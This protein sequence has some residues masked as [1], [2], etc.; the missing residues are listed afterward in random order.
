MNSEIVALMEAEKPW[1]LSSWTISMPTFLMIFLP[2]MAVPMAIV[3]A[4]RISIHSGKP[5]ISP[6]VLPIERAMASMA[7]D[8]NF[9]PSWAPCMRATPAA[10]AICI[11]PKKLFA[12]LR[13][14]FAQ[15]M[16]MIFAMIQPAR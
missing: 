5:P 14:A 1:Y 2:P 13:S 3:A 12:F 16:G 15:A 6:T 7:V 11:L 8:M 10:P 9:W 4:Q